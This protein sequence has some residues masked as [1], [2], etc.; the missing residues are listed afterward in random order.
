MSLKNIKNKNCILWGFLCMTITL[1][2]FAPAKLAHYQDFYKEARQKKGGVFFAPEDLDADRITQDDQSDGHVVERKKHASAKAAHPF[3]PEEE[4]AVSLEEGLRRG[5][6]QKPK[7]QKKAHHSK[8]DSSVTP[9][10]TC[11]PKI[12][13]NM[14]S[15]EQKEPQHLGGALPLDPQGIAAQNL[16]K[17]I[18]ESVEDNFQKYLK[19]HEE[20]KSYAAMAKKVEAA[21]VK[22]AAL[23]E[24]YKG[25]EK[26]L[27]A[28]ASHEG[29]QKTRMPQASLQNAPEVLMQPSAAPAPHRRGAGG[30]RRSK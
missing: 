26:A 14:P 6:A 4:K 9:A 11:N 12:I 16:Q 18:A 2:T 17:K 22:Q 29:A 5:P 28:I 23:Q 25:M 7:K 24:Q 30:K 15:L 19:K 3:R 20:E 13:I 21:A 27:A 8:H 1:S 10:I